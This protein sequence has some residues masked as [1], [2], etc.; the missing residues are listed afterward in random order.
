MSCSVRWKDPYF[1]TLRR[2]WPRTRDTYPLSTRTTSPG[3]TD[4]IW[5]S[6]SES[7]IVPVSSPTTASANWRDPPNLLSMVLRSPLLTTLIKTFVCLVSGVRSLTFVKGF[8]SAMF[9]PFLCPPCLGLKD[10][11]FREH[12]PRGSSEA[13]VRCLSR[14]DGGRYKNLWRRIR[15]AGPNRQS[16]VFE[17]TLQEVGVPLE[18]QEP[19]AAEIEGDHACLARLLRLARELHDAFDCVRR[20]R[21]GDQALRL[22]EEPTRFE[23]AELVERARLDDALVQEEA[24]RRRG[25]VVAEPARVD[26]WRHEVVAERVHLHEGR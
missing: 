8:S 14:S 12:R 24:Q 20:L 2:M 17:T 26:A 21:G 25:P 15:R 23:R 4:S 9:I 10:V 19:V 5:S 16:R 3:C 11:S 1:P 6:Q 22:R 13:V 18:V 7:R